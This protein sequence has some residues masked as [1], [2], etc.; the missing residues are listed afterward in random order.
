M[1]AATPLG[2]SGRSVMSLEGAVVARLGM[3]LNDQRVRLNGMA[4]HQDLGGLGTA[5]PDPLQDYRVQ[6]MKELGANAW[7]CAHNPP[8]P[9]LVSAMDRL[10]MVAMVENRRFGPADNYD[11]HHAAPPVNSTQIAADV[12]TMVRTFRNSP[13]VVLWSL[14]NEEGCFE[15]PDTDLPGLAVGALMKQLIVRTRRHPRGDGSDERRHVFRT[16]KRS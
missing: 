6:K 13:S 10:G 8:N 1:N 16:R 15:H 11:K 4:N 5:V 14:C 9:A 2:A 7:R 3:W 12:V